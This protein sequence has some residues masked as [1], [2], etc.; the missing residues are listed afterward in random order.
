MKK[1]ILTLIFILTT[2]LNA[3][4]IVGSVSKV[5]GSVKVKNEGSF[6]K[7]KVKEKQKVR[8]GDLITT[9]KKGRVVIKLVD[10]SDVVLDKS[11]SI[12]FSK[13]NSLE[14]KGGK[15]F[16]KISS[17]DA[18]NSLKIKTPFAIIGIKGTTFTINADNDNASVALK[19]G[20]IGVTSIEEEF[21]LYRKEVLAKYN[22]YVTEQMKGFEKFKGVDKP[23]PEITKEFDLEAGNVIS[24]SKNVVEESAW[25]DKDDAEFD[26]YEKMLDSDFKE[27]K[28][29]EDSEFG[30]F[31]SKLNSDEK[32]NKKRAIDAMRKNMDF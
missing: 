20:R 24:F 2:S 23:E 31:D 19:E 30:E 29:T 12:H 9:S 6:K 28:D 13:N 3:S 16:Y 11:S 22:E 18:K 27:S 25:D 8:E 26:I 7:S 14:Q 15:I 4:A 32:A 1:M 21:A 17:R 10:G 5:V